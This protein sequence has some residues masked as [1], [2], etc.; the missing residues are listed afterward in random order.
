M[1]QIMSTDNG[2]VIGYTNEPRYIKVSTSGSYIQAKNSDEALGVAY[3]G[4]AY[5]LIDT[6]GV[7]ANDT[8]FV[9]YIDEGS[10]LNNIEGLMSAIN[11]IED[12]LCELDKEVEE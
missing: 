10:L 7:G 2:K 1:Y 4:K 12:A 3:L 9:S 5:N 11:E 8:V 6:D